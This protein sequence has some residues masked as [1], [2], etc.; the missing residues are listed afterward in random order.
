MSQRPFA[1]LLAAP[2]LLA[3][4][5][6]AIVLP[7]P[8]VIYSPAYTV[9]VLGEDDGKEIIE[10][11]GHRTYEDDGQLRMTIV[12]VT[13]PDG[14]VTLFDA[15]SAW[16]DDERSVYPYDSVYRPNETQ[17]QS[18]QEGAAQMVSAKDTAVAM[19]LTELG[20]YV[21]QIT[22]REVE[23]GSPA[24][25]IFRVGDRLLTVDGVRVHTSADV[26]AAIQSAAPG[27]PV[28]F[29]VRRDGSRRTLR[30]VPRET[31]GQR[32]IGIQLDVAVDL[33]FQVDINIDPAIGGPSAGLMFAL[34]T[35]DR[36]TPGSLTDGKAVAGTG[37]IDLSGRVGPI[38]GIQQKIVAARDEGVPLFLVP[39]DNCTDAVRSPNG[40]MRLVKV[41]T[42][43]D[44]L[45]SI[46]TWARDKNAALPACA[47]APS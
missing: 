17:E 37:T 47:G 20:Y 35:Y 5:V 46:E 45:T 6:A 26:S 25:G 8:Y 4:V 14:R 31:D 39:A 13:Q 18:Q 24:E 22:V 16:L 11:T 23:A 43:D 36:L 34:A 7:L 27:A 10:V 19:A 30:V 33:P 15:M 3:L 44:A 21:E 12:Y 9:N 28:S 1:V 42:L 32:R 38:G 41:S 2:L 29:G 40:P